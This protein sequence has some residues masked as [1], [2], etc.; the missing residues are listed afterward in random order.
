MKILLTQLHVSYVAQGY[1]YWILFWKHSIHASCFR[2]I[3]M[4]F[5][6][7]FITEPNQ[8]PFKPDHF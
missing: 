8:K 3:K 5:F 4:E 2:G 1:G 6:L 7:K